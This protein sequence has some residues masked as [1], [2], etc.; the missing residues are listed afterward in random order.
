MKYFIL[1]SMTATLLATGFIGTVSIIQSTHSIAHASETF[2]KEYTQAPPT[3]KDYNTKGKLY[4]I[5][6]A[7]SHF[8]TTHS[9]VRFQNGSELKLEL[10]GR[11][12]TSEAEEKISETVKEVT[13]YGA[14]RGV[15]ETIPLEKLDNLDP[16]TFTDF[17][18]S[19]FFNSFPMGTK[20][21]LTLFDGTKV[22][23]TYGEP[24]EST[25]ID[26]DSR[27]LIKKAEIVTP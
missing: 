2:I 8:P 12:D 14:E 24:L 27:I 19:H 23:Y 20:V 1:K 4:D 9:I 6:Y 21:T 7:N 26:N 11:P 18:D 22:H 10:N 16:K 17:Y 3:Q 15:E 5:V 13:Y 25:G